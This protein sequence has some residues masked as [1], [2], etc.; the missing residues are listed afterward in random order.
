MLPRLS[1]WS[2]ALGIVSCLP[3]AGQAAPAS[4]SY[5]P[6]TVYPVLQKAGCQGCHN[7]DG[8]ASATRLR[9][10]EAG[11]SA[12]QV[13]TFGL[14][15]SR[16]VD[17]ADPS[18]SPLLNKP[19]ARVA[20]AGG[21]R[22]TPGSPEE[23]VLRTWVGV[24]ASR[25]PEA[26]AAEPE[27]TTPVTAKV[28]VRRL[29]HRQY[30]NTVRDLLGDDSKLADQFPPEDFV[31][32]FKNQFQSQSISPLLAEAYSA[33]AEKLATN[34]FRGGDTKQ[35]IPCKPTGM[36]DA[37]CADTFV[38][39]FGRKAFR[40]PLKPEEATRY[41]ALL[42]SEAR[43]ERDFAAGARMVVEA[44]LQ[45]PRFLL[46]VEHGPDAS[47]YARASQL[48]YSL[49]NTMPDE[50]LFRSAEKGELD[51]A[52]GVERVARLMLADAK[53]R[54]AL[55][56]FV[57]QWLRFDRLINSV[58]DRRLFP[59]YSLELAVAMTEE[60]RRL[61][62]DLTW[63]DGDFRDFYKADYAFL[64]SDLAALY[65]VPAP[66]AEFAKVTLPAD[67]ERAGVLGQA[68]FLAL[69]SKPA[70]TSPTARGLFVR[71]QFLCQEVPQ[72]P[73]GVSTNL[74]PLSA[75]KPQTNRDRLAIHLNNESCASCHN[76]IDP[77]GFGL[78]KFDALGQRREKL[79]LSFPSEHGE[80]KAKPVQ[81]ELP[82]QT[83]GDVA[84]LPQAKFASPR[85]LGKILAESSQCQE[86]VVKQLFRYLSGR[87]ETA[88]DRPVIRQAL[89]TFQN[90]QFRL[91]ELLV[92]LV[93]QNVASPERKLSRAAIR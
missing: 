75:A 21:K 30:N 73:P 84:G 93:T 90:S 69:T 33:A 60:T 45:S 24:L 78:E 77:I 57:S 6:E 63:N 34:A 47:A 76:L 55:D 87:R 62:A 35:L 54:P 68:T 51:S 1:H 58:K 20:H 32:G 79:T 28:A 12:K 5:F 13:T 52:E 46:L 74:P 7:P 29:T 11:V 92:S 38:R 41:S 48:S 86:C 61:V 2:I 65:H 15:L 44:M 81:V 50:A 8:V 18:R 9:F 10:P 37:R 43:K 16:L 36:A 71:E 82:L 22:I 39:S 40:R 91:K 56:E 3:L 70:E 53:A 14:S 25:P 72:P 85:E 31:N 19:T 26:A 23:A 80:R 64:S 89:T 67:T 4:D 42:L 27:E 83:D 88:A 59:M 17:R 66:S 49:W